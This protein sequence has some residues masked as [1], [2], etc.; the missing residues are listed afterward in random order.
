MSPK[1]NI[2]FQIFCH[3]F[4]LGYH[5]TAPQFLRRRVQDVELN[6]NGEGCFQWGLMSYLWERRDS[7]L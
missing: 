6:H 7:F 1:I 2:Y 4:L 5:A 3:L